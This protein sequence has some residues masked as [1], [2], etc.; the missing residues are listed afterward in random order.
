MGALVA[1]ATG[2][3]ITGILLVFEMTNDYALVV[4]LMVAVVVTQIVARKLQ[5]DN[6]YSG[7]LR[8]RG[9]HIEL[10]A[11]RDVLAGLRVADA[12]ERD[13]VVVSEDAPVSHLLDHLGHRD[14]TLFPVVDDGGQYVGVLSAADLGR[15][16]PLPQGSGG[17]GQ[18]RGQG[19]DFVAAL[20][21]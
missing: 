15:V 9:E 12:C 16:H 20:Q 19:A 6:L 5:R 21:Q 18:S 11:D 17:V 13:A 2:A 10:G 8:R 14:Q 7:W 4:P 3:P 1:G